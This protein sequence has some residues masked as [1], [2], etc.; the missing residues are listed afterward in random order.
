MPKRRYQTRSTAHGADSEASGSEA[1]SK[2]TKEPPKSTEK[3]PHCQ[4]GVKRVKLQATSDAALMVPQQAPATPRLFTLP[5]ELQTMIYEYLV[6]EPGCIGISM[7]KVGQTSK[8]QRWELDTFIEH[9]DET[10][11]IHKPA[12]LSVCR[13]LRSFAAPI[14]FTGNTFGIGAMEFNLKFVEVLW[15]MWGENVKHIRNIDYLYRIRVPYFC[16]KYG[17]E[18]KELV[19]VTVNMKLLESGKINLSLR[20][21]STDTEDLGSDEI[22][23]CELDGVVTLLQNQGNDNRRLFEIMTHYKQDDSKQLARPE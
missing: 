6:L 9:P 15:K 19:G 17:Y 22:C 13:Y 3:Q 11:G 8:T 5:A 23:Q 1:P 4:R 16:K 21:S 12:L 20:T 7:R 10:R 2:T 18:R 14:Y